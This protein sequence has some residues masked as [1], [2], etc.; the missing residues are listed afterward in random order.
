MRTI[1]IGLK[2]ILENLQRYFRGF[3]WSFQINRVKSQ[4]LPWVGYT[5]GEALDKEEDWRIKAKAV[6]LDT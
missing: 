5:S 1:L 2:K 3:E 4:R 6:I